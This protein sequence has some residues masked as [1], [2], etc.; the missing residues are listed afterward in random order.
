MIESLRLQNFQKHEDIELNFSELVTCLVGPSDVGKSACIRALLW[1]STNKPPKGNNL[2]IGARPHGII[3]V[4]ITAD[5]H[6]IERTKGP[7][8]NVF[9]LNDKTYNA[10]KRELPDEIDTVLNLS[11]SNFSMQLDGP[12]WFLLS[13]G[14]ISKELNSIVN[15]SQIDKTLSL[16]SQE[17]KN[18]KQEVKIT[19][20]RLKEAR[21]EVDKLAWIVEA[22]QE[23][24]LIQ[25]RQ[26]EQDILLT[27]LQ[28]L[29]QILSRGKELQESVSR[30]RQAHLSLN[31]AYSLA[32]KGTELEGKLDGLV[33]LSLK[34]R[35]SI[36]YISS[37]P[38]QTYID[39]LA[40]MISRLNGLTNKI[41]SLESL[42]CEIRQA[43]ETVLECNQQSESAKDQLAK[44]LGEGCPLCGSTN[45]KTGLKVSKY[46]A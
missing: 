27:K 33:N 7:K 44:I 36:D 38:S 1:A 46:S 10:I 29:G 39:K 43:K 31:K 34:I 16:A 13:A 12:L 20:N 4:H 26:N 30:A 22:K 28:N 45:Q 25:N 11:R 9:K 37:A 23:Y 15:L 17:V 19:K 21:L 35:Q 18:S 40:K 6:R 5:N 42:A 8:L 14:Q 24:E 3:R 2:R 41:N 32:H